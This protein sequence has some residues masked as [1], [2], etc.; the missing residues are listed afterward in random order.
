MEALN[1]ILSKYKNNVAG[2][3]IG[4]AAGY[5]LAK[6]LGYEKTITVIPFCVVGSILGA[7]AE[8][9]IKSRKG[10]PTAEMTK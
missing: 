10:I 4:V 3:V 7:T 9:Y 8:H 6:K 1:S 5:L 2:T